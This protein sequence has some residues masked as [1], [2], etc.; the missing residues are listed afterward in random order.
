MLLLT[1]IPK[2]TRNELGHTTTMPVTKYSEESTVFQNKGQQPD[3]TWVIA[4][5]ENPDKRNS[6]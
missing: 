6:I 1:V 4:L 3:N 5:K 2:E